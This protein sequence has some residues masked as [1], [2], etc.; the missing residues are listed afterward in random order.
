M[1]CFFVSVYLVYHLVGFISAPITRGQLS[2]IDFLQQSRLPLVAIVAQDAYLFYGLLLQE[3]SYNGK[4]R[5]IESWSWKEKIANEKEKEN[6]GQ[7]T[8]L[9]SSLRLN[10][11]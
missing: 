10:G 7:G 6:T 9:L 3:W 1:H 8:L 4:G 2:G 5:L 11:R